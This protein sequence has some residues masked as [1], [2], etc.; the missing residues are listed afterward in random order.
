M[1]P[2][3]SMWADH[4]DETQPACVHAAAAQRLRLDALNGT[5]SISQNRRQYGFGS[6]I[7]MHVSLKTIYIFK[8]K[9]I[10]V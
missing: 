7:T 9:D 5:H 10:Y 6:V 3:M 1:P 8:L 4:R 2:F